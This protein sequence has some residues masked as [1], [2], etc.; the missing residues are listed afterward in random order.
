MCDAAKCAILVVNNIMEE[1][2]RSDVIGY[3]VGVERDR[4]IDVYVFY[5]AANLKILEENGSSVEIKMRRTATSVFLESG[6][7]DLCEF[8]DS[9]LRGFWDEFRRVESEAY[10]KVGVDASVEDFPVCHTQGRTI[11]ETESRIREVLGL[12]IDDDKAK[13]DNRN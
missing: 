4:D 6:N 10:C 3:S 12:F 7:V 5:V 8:A 13:L 11:Q 1:M 2:N 9:L